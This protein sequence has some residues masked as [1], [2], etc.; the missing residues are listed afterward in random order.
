MRPQIHAFLRDEYN[1]GWIRRS[2]YGKQCMEIGVQC[3]Y[4]AVVRPSK[5]KNLFIAC[6]GESALTGV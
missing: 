6:G 4:N 3:A 5:I 2:G 1:Y